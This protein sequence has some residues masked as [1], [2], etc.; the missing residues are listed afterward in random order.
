MIIGFV[1]A[2][3][4]SVNSRVEEMGGDNWFR[5]LPNVNGR[6]YYVKCYISRQLSRDYEEMGRYVRHG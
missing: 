4:D 6:Q 1:M 3:K 5:Y 2:V